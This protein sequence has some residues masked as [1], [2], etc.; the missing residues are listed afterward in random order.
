V[1]R[2]LE[3]HAQQVDGGGVAVDRSAVAVPEQDGQATAVVEMAMAE[4]DG[5]DP[6]RIERQRIAVAPLVLAAALEQAAIQQDALA[7]GV[8]QVAGAGY[9]PGGAEAGHVHCA[10]SG[11]GGWPQRISPAVATRPVRPARGRGR[12][13]IGYP[14]PA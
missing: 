9:F 5:V 8:H 13:R 12:R 4:H 10:R 6:L 1:R 3:Q 2:I 14:A 7:S 11:C